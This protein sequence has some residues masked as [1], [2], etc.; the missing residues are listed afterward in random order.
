MRSVMTILLVATFGCSNG[1]TS[2]GNDMSIDDLS[3]GGSKP[4]LSMGSGAC[5]VAAQTGCSGTQKCIPQF[6]G[7]MQNPTVMGLCVDNGTV[8]EG[9][10]CTPGS[11]MT[12]LNDDCKAGLTCD[13]IADTSLTNFA[14]RKFCTADAG[15]TTGQKCA[16]A[17]DPS[18]N[19]G[20]CLPTC[21]PFTG[22]ECAAGTDCSVSFYDISATQTTAPGFFV[23]KD[24]G[25]GTLY[26]GCQ[27]NTD[28]GANLSCD[29]NNSWCAGNCNNT[30]ACVQPDADGGV[31]VMC[32]TFDGDP[33]GA[34]FCG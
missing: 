1:G 5:D 18:V 17:V 13:W 19:Y 33:N 22:T 3:M 8:A 24:T 23:C 31:T 32:N 14:C 15:C 2:P 4:D 30:T 9:A 34:G 27:D 16:G 28:C 10:P 7:T 29:F 20:F 21:T 12:Q 11:D 6:G 26:S 25:A